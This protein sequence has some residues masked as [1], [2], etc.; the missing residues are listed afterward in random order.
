MSFN[1]LYPSIPCHVCLVIQVDAR[2]GPPD[3]APA[4]STPRTPAG[5]API[6]RRRKANLAAALGTATAPAGPVCIAP[7]VARA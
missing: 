5:V 2:G 3:A 1:V 4:G 6:A 7:P